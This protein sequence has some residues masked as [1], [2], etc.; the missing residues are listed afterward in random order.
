MAKTRK[1]HWISTLTQNKQVNNICVYKR[2]KP[3]KEKKKSS[4]Y[5]NFDHIINAAII[6][7]HIDILF[8]HQISVVH[9]DENT[10]LEVT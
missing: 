8:F 1:R 10:Q 9:L 7:Q 6:A 2:V 3:K 5:E 4:S